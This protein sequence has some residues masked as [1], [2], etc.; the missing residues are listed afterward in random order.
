VHYTV[1]KVSYALTPPPDTN[2]TPPIVVWYDEDNPASATLKA[3]SSS[4]TALVFLILGIVTLLA[5]IG[6]G[7]AYTRK[8]KKED[9]LSTSIP[10]GTSSAGA[11]T[12]AGAASGAGEETLGSG[13]GSSM[14][15]FTVN[16]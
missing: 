2:L 16:T 7:Y 4:K 10:Q 3:P 1:N 5:S 15:S 12:P 13:T 9:E 6:T 11:G 8:K 14:G